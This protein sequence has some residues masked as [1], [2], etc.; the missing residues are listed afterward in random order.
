MP[1]TKNAREARE[2]N[3]LIYRLR[4]A[5]NLFHMLESEAG[6]EA[7]NAELRELG[8]AEEPRPVKR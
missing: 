3:W 4:A 5:Y 8:A 1:I 2:R 6:M 7:T